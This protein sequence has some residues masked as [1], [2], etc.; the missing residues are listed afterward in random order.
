[1]DILQEISQF[2]QAGR[3]KN[4]VELVTK[5]LESGMEPNQILEEALLSGMSII[6]EKF[7]NEEVFVPEVLISARAMSRGVEVLKPYLT[8]GNASEKGV[9]VLGT[10][11]G[12]FHDIGKNLVRIMFEGK[13]IKVIDLG[14][15]VTAETFIEQAKEHN[16]DIICCSALLTTT[17]AEMEKVVRLVKEGNM[18]FKVMIGGAPVNQEYCDQI[19]ADYYTDDAASAADVARSIIGGH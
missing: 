6:G 8:E 13:G 3:A 19:G 11:K 10:V 15:D 16:A 12:D 9:A 14:I 17:M 4:V 1:M 5:A 7:K 2:L 18:P